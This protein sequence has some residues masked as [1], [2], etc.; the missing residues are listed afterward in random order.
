MVGTGPD[1]VGEFIEIL[2]R[3]LVAGVLVAIFFAAFSSAISAMTPRRGIASAAIVM[4][5]FIPA[6]VIGVLLEATDIGDELDLLNVFG[7]PFRASQWILD[8]V[9]DIERGLEQVSGPLTTL[10]T[11]ATAALFAGITWWRYQNLEVER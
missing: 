1:G 9:P 7:L 4:V 11:V 2:F 6:I 3:I 5:M 10:V 8:G